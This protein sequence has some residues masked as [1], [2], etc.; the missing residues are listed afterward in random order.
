MELVIEIIN[1]LATCPQEMPIAKTFGYGASAMNY[2][3]PTDELVRPSITGK[4]V[5]NQ[6]A[7]CYTTTLSNCG[8][9][10]EFFF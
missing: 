8:N 6:C 5:E 7:A 2:C 9:Y 1:A 10:G 3:C 4:T